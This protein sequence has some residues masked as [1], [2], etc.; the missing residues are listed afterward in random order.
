MSKIKKNTQQE[1]DEQRKFVFT[2]KLVDEITQKINDGVIL[3]R[4]QNP[5]FKGEVGVRRSG[6]TFAISNDELEEYIKCKLDLEYFAEKY[7]KIKKENGSIGNISLRDYQRDILKL[8]KSPK[9][10][11][12]GSR[13][14]GKC[15]SGMSQIFLKDKKLPIYKIY[16]DSLK[17]IRPLTILE[18]VKNVLYNI[19]YR[20]N[21]N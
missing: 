6:L 17:K 13:Q 12:C 16:Y 8:Y 7:C 19:A 20:F 21:I 18:K 4:Y 10:I 1:E 5:W 14:I 15:L 2:T 9:S 3:K 11:L